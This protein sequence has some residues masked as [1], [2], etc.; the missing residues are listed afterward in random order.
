MGQKLYTRQ[1]I[2]TSITNA[3]LNVSKDLYN[4]GLDDLSTMTLNMC[5]ICLS[6]I[7]ESKDELVQP[8][9]PEG[10]VK[11]VMF[12]VG[13]Q[14]NVQAESEKPI[15]S[16]SCSCSEEKMNCNGHVNPGQDA[17][18]TACQDACQQESSQQSIESEVT[19]IVSKIRQQQG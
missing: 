8:R 10:A 14:I 5:D 9:Q 12:N 13:E 2:I 19:E 7:D 3:L 15:D 16:C 11:E 4:L 17:C 1:H 18:Q 6:H